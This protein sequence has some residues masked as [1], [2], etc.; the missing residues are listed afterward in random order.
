M[1]CI[2]EFTKE[3]T[4]INP[5]ISHW[6][7][8]NSPISFSKVKTLGVTWTHGNPI[9]ESEDFREL[10]LKKEVDSLVEKVR[11]SFNGLTPCTSLSKIRLTLNGDTSALGKLKGIFEGQAGRGVEI[12]VDK[13]TSRFEVEWRERY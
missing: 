12:V 6:F 4:K 7:L 2:S 3:P 8:Q 10:P 13:R 9:R 5:T 11:K 1:L